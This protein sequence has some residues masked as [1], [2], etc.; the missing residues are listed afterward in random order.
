MLHGKRSYQEVLRDKSGL[1]TSL[2]DTLGG[3]GLKTIGLSLAGGV[4]A[5]LLVFWVVATS[6]ADTSS[7]YQTAGVNFE[8]AVQGSDV[9]IGSGT[10]RV[11]LLTDTA[12][13]RCEV[14]TWQNGSRDGRTTLHVDTKTVP[15]VCTPTTALIALGK[16]DSAQELIFNIE[17]PVFT[18]SNLGGRSITFDAAGAPTLATGAKAEGVKP[19]DWDDVR[20][21]SVKL[22]L[23]TLNE[24]TSKVTQKAELSGVTNVVNVS[25]GQDDNRYVPPP[26]TDPVPG[27]LRITS[28]LRSTTVGTPYSGAREG[29]EVSVAGGVC[30][31]GP[32]KLTAS[33]TQQSPSAAAAVT[34]VLS[35]QL[36]GAATPINIGSTPNGSSGAVD[37]SATCI[38]GGVVETTATGFTQAVPTPVLTVK[39]N[40]QADKHDLS[41]T[42]VS[43]LPTQYH[44]EWSSTNKKTGKLDLPGLTTTVT[45]E[46]GTVYGFT[47]TY[48][49][50]AT[51]NNVTSGD[52]TAAISNSWPAV[53]KPVLTQNASN[54]DKVQWNW[55][56]V[57]CPAGTIAEY[58]SA[59]WRHDIGLSAW[60]TPGT[61]P[62]YSVV[63]SYQGY[64][65]SVDAKARCRSAVTGSFSDYS[66]VGNGPRFT[67]V[68]ENP[69]P[70]VFTSRQSGDRTLYTTPYTYCTGGARIYMWL[71]EASWDIIWIGGPN[72]GKTGWWAP[73]PGGWYEHGPKVIESVNWNV[74]GPIPKGSRYQVRVQAQ[75]QVP[76]TGRNSGLIKQDSQMLVW[77]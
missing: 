16:G 15:G 56:A 46:L 4:L 41:W 19:V 8:R 10:N 6:S 28:V 1:S 71:V 75:C 11:G 7:G 55:K 26:S 58:S 47:T 22:N 74:Q 5:T 54:K 9:V 38:E 51:V 68:V 36:T 49:V 12:D 17:T 62:A 34:A 21:Y 30:P 37:V 39:Q 64:D 57:S 50:R 52:S 18:F 23:T 59:Y 76:A 45:H 3:I 65:Y 73:Q 13:G 66:A 14:Q 72:N 42:Q 20:P 44:V 63:T 27:P 40:A 31:S 67:R 32:T 43:S 33:Y 69:A 70:V 29:V 60:T 61:S 24:R 77:K 48:K 25:V 35:K 53:A 2:A